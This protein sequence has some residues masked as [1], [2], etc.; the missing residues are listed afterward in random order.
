MADRAQASEPL[1]IVWLKPFEVALEIVHG[2]GIALGLSLFWTMEGVR[3]RIFRLLD[4]ANARS[5]TRPASAF[6]PG[7]PRKHPPRRAY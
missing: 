2:I 4:R 6:P 1:E 5:R 7:Q 3:D